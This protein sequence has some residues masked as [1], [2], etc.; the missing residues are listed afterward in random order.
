MTYPV[1]RSTATR[2][3]SVD[4]ETALVSGGA[5]VVYSPGDV[6]L[7]RWSLATPAFESAVNATAAIP[8]PIDGTASA[9]GTASYYV[10]ATSADVEAWRGPAGNL[11]LPGPIVEGAVYR[12]NAFEHVATNP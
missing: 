10:V 3:A 11:S 2:N 4:A 1:Q 12:L 5:I 9:S 6:E 7:V 8:D